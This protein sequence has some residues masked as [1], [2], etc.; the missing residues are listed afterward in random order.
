MSYRGFVDSEY[1]V[2]DEIK[3][4]RRKALF[5]NQGIQFKRHF[6]KLYSSISNMSFF[7]QNLFLAPRTRFTTVNRSECDQNIL[8][9]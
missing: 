5:I 8:P 6:K 4:M 2:E 1:E 7:L 9:L 3:S